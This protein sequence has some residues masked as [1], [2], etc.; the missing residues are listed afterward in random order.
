MYILIFIGNYKFNFG[1]KYSR[2]RGEFVNYEFFRD[3]RLNF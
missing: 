2:K 3:L 1:F